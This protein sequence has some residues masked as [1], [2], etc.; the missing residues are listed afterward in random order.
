MNG[1]IIG[2]IGCNKCTSLSSNWEL[3]IGNWELGIGNWELGIGELGIG[4]L[5]N[6]ALGIVSF[7]SFFSLPSSFFGS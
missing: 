1:R 7:S 3:V 6:W 2:R 5:G 4:E